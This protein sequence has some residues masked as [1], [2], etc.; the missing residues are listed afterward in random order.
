M[1]KNNLKC[2]RTKGKPGQGRIVI[3]KKLGCSSCKHK[4]KGVQVKLVKGRKRLMKF[5]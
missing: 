3:V 4:K 1:A 5:V 2:I